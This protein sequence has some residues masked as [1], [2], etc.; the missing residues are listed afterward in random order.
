MK[1]SAR[2]KESGVVAGEGATL[3]V[4]V[5]R[6]ASEAALPRPQPRQR[7]SGP[8]PGRVEHRLLKKNRRKITVTVRNLNVTHVCLIVEGKETAFQ[9]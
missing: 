5:A 7:A 6:A 9:D 2:S 8:G 4:V 3:V 1:G